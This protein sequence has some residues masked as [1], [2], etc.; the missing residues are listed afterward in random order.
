MATIVLPTAVSGSFQV[1]PSQLLAEEIQRQASTRDQQR[2]DAY[3]RDIESQLVAREQRQQL[4]R[5]MFEESMRQTQQQAD[6]ATRK[7][8]MAQTAAE[9]DA[10]FRQAEFERKMKKD[11]LDAQ[12]EQERVNVLQ[13]NLKVAQDRLQLSEEEATAGAKNKRLE[14]Q[15]E[16]EVELAK[17]RLSAQLKDAW[18]KRGKL[19]AEASQLEPE[20]QEAQSYQQLMSQQQALI[21]GIEAQL[22][23]TPSFK[24]AK[25][26]AAE[27]PKAPIERDDE[28]FIARVLGYNES[29]PD[30]VEM[31]Q[32]QSPDMR[33]AITTIR[34]WDDIALQK[35][36]DSAMALPDDAPN[37]QIMTTAIQRE[38]ALRGIQATGVSESDINTLLGRQ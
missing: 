23:R 2:A 21:S 29:D 12:R 33:Q 35:A 17:Q 31:Y 20:T 24:S 30:S 26:E 11:V 4:E 18:I 14:R 28:N 37:K 1:D 25:K 22:G 5:Q 32:K 6:I 3:I 16:Q 8:Q 36:L 34:R 19:E 38:L 9:E 15:A 13:G 10:A 7:L 27:K